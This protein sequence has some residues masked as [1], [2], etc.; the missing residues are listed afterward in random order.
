MVPDPVN[1]WV[2]DRKA[3]ELPPVNDWVAV[4]DS[5]GVNWLTISLQDPLAKSSSEMV[6]DAAKEER[7]DPIVRAAARRTEGRVFKV[8]SRVQM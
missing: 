7:L 5:P 2:I 3:S 6:M 8:F 4:W 1:P